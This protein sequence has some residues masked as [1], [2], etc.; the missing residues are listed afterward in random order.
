M[1][2]ISCYISFVYTNQVAYIDY[3]N[4]CVYTPNLQVQLSEYDADIIMFMVTRL[5]HNNMYTALSRSAKHITNV[6]TILLTFWRSVCQSLCFDNV[7]LKYVFISIYN[8]FTTN[9]HFVI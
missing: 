8:P 2:D 1:I 3:N 6:I 4:C 7:A 5:N 9:I